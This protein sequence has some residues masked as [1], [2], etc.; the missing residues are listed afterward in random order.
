MKNLI[1]NEKRYEKG[2]SLI[3]S[4]CKNLTQRESRGSLVGRPWVVRESM[5]RRWSVDGALMEDRWSHDSAKNANMQMCK[6][7][8]LHFC[9]SGKAHL[10]RLAAMLLMLVMMSIGQV[11]G[12]SQTYSITTPSQN[13]YTDPTSGITVIGTAT[14]GKIDN[15]TSQK[16]FSA[17]KG[18]PLHITSIIANI[19]GIRFDYDDSSSG[20][21]SENIMNI[22]TSNGS[23]LAAPTSGYTGNISLNG[24]ASTSLPASLAGLAVGKDQSTHCTISV[25]FTSAVST[26]VVNTTGSNAAQIRNLVIIYD[27]EILARNLYATI[28]PTGA[29]TYS[30]SGEGR[31]TTASVDKTTMTIG[32]SDFYKLSSTN[33]YTPTESLVAGDIVVFTVGNTSSKF[34]GINVESAGDLSVEKGIASQSYQIVYVVPAAK[35]SISFVRS[36]SDTYLKDIRVY[37]KTPAVC[38][39]PGKPTIS[40]GYHYFP[41]ET[42]ALT[43]S[44]TGTSGSA[45]Y[46]WKKDGGE[47]AGQTTA[48][49]NIASCTAANAGK[50]TVV[51]SNGGGCES[52]SSNEYSV[53]ILQSY[54][55]DNSGTDLYNAPLTKVD[56][57]HARISF[58]LSGNTTYR[59]NITDGCNNWYGNDG[60]MNKDNC[61][62]WAF[63][64]SNDCRITTTKA[65]VYVVTVDYSNLA[66]PVVSVEYPSS[67]QA[68]GKTIYFDNSERNW[69]ES[70]IYYRI[71]KGDYNSKQQMTKVSGTANL[72]K[73]VTNGFDGFEAWHIAN[74][75]CWSEGHSIYKTNTGDGLAAT[76]AVK[77]I[78]N[79]VTSTIIVVPTS[80]H[81]KGTDGN[82][83]NCEFYSYQMVDGMKSHT[84]TI[85]APSNGTITVAYTDVNGAA[86]N[87][88]SGNRDLAH[89]CILTI[90]A[91]PNTGYSLSGVTVNGGAFTSG[92]TH[93][94]SADATIAATFAAKT[95][96]ITINA[97]TANHGS[98]APAAITATYG[99]SLPAFTAAAGVSGYQLKGYYTAATDGT[100]VINADGTLV[101][102][103]N[104]YT[105]SSSKWIKEDA[106][107]T[108][109]AQYEEAASGT[110]VCLDLSKGSDP[111]NLPGGATIT[112]GG[113]VSYSKDAGVNMSDNAHYF[114][115]DFSG[116][117]GFGKITAITY[118]AKTGSTGSGKQINYG[119]D[120]KCSNGFAA[121]GNHQSTSKSNYDEYVI[122]SIPDNTS[123]IAFRRG[124]TGTIISNVCIT[125][126][127]VA[128][129]PG[130]YSITYDCDGAES[131]CPY[132]V[133]SAT[134][135]PNPLPAA[136]VKSGY[137]F[138]AWYT[139]SGKTT[140]AVAGAALTENTTLYA[141]WKPQYTVTLDN[142]S[143]TTPGAASVTVTYGSK[144]NIASGSPVAPVNITMPTK[145]GYTFGGY[146]TDRNGAGT[147]LIDEAGHFIANVN[148]YTDA[149]YTWKKASNVTLY[150]K[151]TPDAQATYTVTVNDEAVGCARTLK[152]VAVGVTVDIQNTC[153]VPGKHL[154]GY[155]PDTVPNYSFNAETKTLTFTMPA[156]NV[157]LTA[158]WEVDAPRDECTLFSY[159]AT[160]AKSTSAP[161]KDASL[162]TNT[163]GSMTVGQAIVARYSASNSLDAATAGYLKFGS[164]DV[165]IEIQLASPYKIQVGDVITIV[166]KTGK[167]G[168][169]RRFSIA[170]SSVDN[171]GTGGIDILNTPTSS[172]TDF[173]YSVAVTSAWLKDYDSDIIR[174]FRE[175]G[176]TMYLKSI[177]VTRPNCDVEACT[178]PVLPSLEN[179]TLCVGENAVAWNATQTAELEDG[180][181]VT[182]QWKRGSTV[183]DE[184]GA[185]LSLTNVKAADA[186]T[187]TVT[188]TVSADGK[189]S[190]SAS[191]T[192]T[193]TV[194]V[195]P[196]VPTI[197][198][199]LSTI[200][201]GNEVTL[202]AT[203]AT[204]GVTYQWYTCDEDGSNES[205]IGG[206]TNATYT[207]ASAPGAGTYYYMVRVNDGKG[208][209]CSTTDSEVHTMTV[210]AP[211]ECTTHYWFYNIAN[212]TKAGK[213]NDA[214]FFSGVTTGTSNSGSY[215]LNVDGKDFEV[216]SRLSAGAYSVSFT[217]Q[218][219][220]TGT[221]D[222]TAKAN[223]SGYPLVI[224][225]TSDGEVM[226]ITTSTTFASYRLTDIEPGTWTITSGAGKNWYYGAMAVTVCQESS[227][228]DAVPTAAADN[229]GICVG[230]TVTLTASGATAD[231]TYQWYKGTDAIVGA[232]NATYTISTATVGDAGV[233]HVV[234]TKD[235][236]RESNTVT[237]SVLTAPV[238]GEYDKTESVMVSQRLF[239]ND[240]EATGA[241]SY[242]WYK[243][244]DA[245]FNIETDTKVGE[246]KNLT[247]DADAVGTF[248]LFCVATNS[249][250]STTSGA[251]TVTV[252]PFKDEE[253]AAKG[254]E[255]SVEFGFDAGGCETA[256]V[257]ETTCWNSNGS[258]KNLVY[259][260]PDGKIFGSVTLTVAVKSGGTTKLVLGY[261][262]DGSSWTYLEKTGLTTSFTEQTYD[263]S[264]YGAV[265]A[266][267]IGR[268]TS[269]SSMGSNSGSVYVAKA[270]FEYGETCYSP[271]IS[272]SVPSKNYEIGSGAFE[273]PAF[274]VI[275][276]N[277]ANITSSATLAYS[278]S[279]EEIATVDAE[280]GEVE[281]EG[282]TGT[283]TITASYAGGT[284]SEQDYCA[285]TGK[286]TIT[287]TCS[288]AA[289]VISASATEITTQAGVTLTITNY[290]GGGSYQ[291]YAD[292]GV[293]MEGETGQNFQ[294]LRSGKYYVVLSNA[295]VQ[296]SNVLTITSNISEPSVK[297]LVPFQYYHAGKSYTEQMKMRH[298]F[299]VKAV[300]NNATYGHYQITATRNGSPVDLSAA[301]SNITNGDGTID[302]VMIDL[303]KL[304]GLLSENDE[305]VFKCA[306]ADFGNNIS[307]SVTATL[308]MHV[309]DQTPTLAY[310]CS[311]AKKDGT[312]TRTTKE[313]TV[314]GDFLTGYNPADTKMQTGSATFDNNTELPLYT[315]LKDSFR[316]TPVNG[317]A[318][319]D[320]LNYEPFDVLLL[321]DYPKASKSDATKKILDDM[322]ALCDYRPMLSFKTHMLQD[323]YHKWE[324]KGFTSNPT[325]PA[326]PQVLM[327]IVCYAHPMFDEMTPDGTNIFLDSNN[328]NE[329]VFKMLSGQGY[330]SNKGIQGFEIAAAENFVVIAQTHYH[331]HGEAHGNVMTPTLDGDDDR[332]LIASC[333]RQKNI[334]A[335]MIMLSLNAGATCK[336]TETGCNV[337]VR[338]LNYL[339][340]TDPLIV[341][342]CHFAFDDAAGDHLWS[343]PGNWAPRHN[344]LPTKN[345]DVRIE[346][347]VTVDIPNA[348]ASTMKV[349]D[350]VTVTI[351]ANAG[352]QL[353]NKARHLEDGELSP[354]EHG[355]LY[356]KSS[357]VGNAAFIHGDEAGST[358]ATVEMY[359][360]ATGTSRPDGSMTNV[361]WQW[362]T[363]PYNDVHDAQYNYYGGWMHEWQNE[364]KEWRQINNG[365]GMTPFLGYTVT[366]SEANHVYWMQGTLAT[367]ADQT[368][369]ATYKGNRP[370]MF[371]NSWTAPIQ[372]EKFE[373]GDFE[374][375][376][377]TIVLFNTGTNTTG[378][379][380]AAAQN[381][382]AGQYVSIPID[383]AASLGD[384]YKVIPS[385][386]AFQIRALRS[387]DPNKTAS[388]QI[389]L[390]LDYDRLVRPT[391]GSVQVRPM[392][393]PGRVVAD[394][395]EELLNGNTAKLVISVKGEQYADRTFL[396]AN[397]SCTNG[398]DNGWDGTKVIGESYAPQL[399][400]ENEAGNWAVSSQPELPGTT[401]AFR[402]GTDSH[403]TI[404]FE[405]IGEEELAL[406]DAETGIYTPI[407]NQAE[408][409]F[410]SSNTEASARF[411]IVR[412]VP[413]VP[414]DIEMG[415]G[416]SGRQVK[417]MI[418]NDMLYI[419]V[420][421]M[422]YNVNGKVVR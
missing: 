277:S 100:K 72:F 346:K 144:T 105:N 82:N 397:S 32:G 21:G 300:G 270:C 20:S 330:E 295:C 151:W 301:L 390:T 407:T 338:S 368:L 210:S 162:A 214:T 16:I 49:L 31:M 19:K 85:T 266:I 387:T 419:S 206:A 30:V 199:S 125:Y 155:T 292:N 289:P 68:A 187:Y 208:N 334:E 315:T 182:Y 127:T 196:A 189:S 246:E 385:M 293:I 90:T 254:A 26:I 12:E 237:I 260:A 410:E 167:S 173:E 119:F 328:P 171:I 34:I 400:V 356:L 159:T 325:V 121:D 163:Y 335:R 395:E 104:G 190:A 275:G 109:Y 239:I 247:L 411:A 348:V 33:T 320:V 198:S 317:Y 290:D 318:N 88:T 71:G 181:S 61:S 14:T 364:T 178:T 306:P 158:V 47:V 286:Y 52:V 197:S 107:V 120:G 117:S 22:Q 312:G 168:E 134:A 393:A 6:I 283:V 200:Y 25:E 371:G 413:Q 216:T 78:G 285:A 4:F 402:K 174:I 324:K 74:N 386:Q 29:N 363:T 64:S 255:G 412:Y 332:I 273:E 361:T 235:C 2:L 194:N 124:G 268:N 309:I 28:T 360:K 291:W 401:L 18:Q 282:K 73:V 80:E 102:S 396:F 96:S 143:A 262:L 240:V 157:T 422:L 212:A 352:L 366:H 279:D 274:T 11:W 362:V 241:T 299:A 344:V 44:A 230:G 160:N 329:T 248:Y 141:K 8:N 59:F 399:Y 201:P 311:G 403:Y 238:F 404:R 138:D 376:V 79:A 271:T 27:D 129:T 122:S 156:S 67:N 251:I 420:D 24:G 43:A 93:V 69:N 296:S 313:M 3:V 131:G 136:P 367:T 253:C 75:G 359:S 414:T 164:N 265:K 15:S 23:S 226:T 37:H 193:L 202:T 287:V 152:N 142:Q 379:Q 192:A 209:T 310:I 365:D 256:S 302:T 140:K 166:G 373:A 35:S 249:C 39:A 94:L 250:G 418:L 115:I 244:A 149:N 264:G 236:E 398:F 258:G 252:T 9:K 84:A 147:K 284:I 42:I 60:T 369:T 354:T 322:A 56:A 384:A 416:G 36:S 381:E 261:S 405:Y 417:K 110:T 55:K 343:T 7:A 272:P 101:A 219:S 353:T 297:V 176:K 227:C 349:V 321:T 81:I 1:I 118:K 148:G 294:A 337:V 319:F 41:G 339:L 377:K 372:I 303:N 278:S 316:V 89:T 304:N 351:N 380:T 130:S 70:K 217:I 341:T 114:C 108:L 38:T 220:S 123:M 191:T 378:T 165:A 207:I 66:R 331:A 153:D 91:T 63:T 92:N 421:G 97:N 232:T 45:T 50:Y 336:L 340:E 177:T 263:L 305:V 137:A 139:N 374:N 169:A 326:T 281:F 221:L 186:G 5:N 76:E 215:N 333:E 314:G 347:N 53:K 161:A 276:K 195:A 223:G 345:V 388:G 185:T 375:L 48:N 184:T 392:R 203:C 222:I 389:S 40:G 205:A 111:P 409:E 183:L 62:N 231:A 383:Q 172:E 128:P 99:Q 257:N 323:G 242:A 391:S 112:L 269:G 280:S 245:T 170:K 267:K 116:I 180:E 358:K 83:N 77:F 145:T 229:A 308:Q 65:G 288:S 95:T 228:T 132:N 103:V 188:A 224:T 350:G 10:A 175:S 204:V 370:Y 126:T 225:R 327:N 298:L 54:L 150:A 243:S 146:F 394:E 213:S 154:T 218:E 259:T 113:E 58:E 13:V 406:Y 408:Y 51:A 233:Y 133:A 57:T 234:A 307:Q 86:Q 342:D 179:Q 211:S 355:D 357:S 46:A 382:I 135:L 106:D 415:P 98:T 17:K 87:F